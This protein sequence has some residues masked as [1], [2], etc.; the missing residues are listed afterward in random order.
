MVLRYEV[1]GEGTSC[2]FGVE[3]VI[4]ASLGKKGSFLDLAQE[5]NLA[6]LD[7]NS[8]LWGVSPSPAEMCALPPP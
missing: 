1:A 3:G 2:R 7:G 4:N 6:E 5:C 8:G